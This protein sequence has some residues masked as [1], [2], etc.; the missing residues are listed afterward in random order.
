MIEKRT[1]II[2]V[3]HGQTAWNRDVRFRGQADLPLDDRGLEE[4][5]ATGCY[6]AQRWPA[7]AVYA[8][9]L[10]RALKTAEAIARAR[11]LTAQ[12]FEGLLDI[13]FGA[14]Q[15]HSPDEVAA[16]YPALLQA[17]WE[18][19]HTVQIPEGESLDDVKDRVVAGLHQ[20][21]ERHRGQTVALVGHSVVNRVLLCAVLGLGNEHFWRLRQDTCAVNVFEADE[22]GTF[23]IVLLNDTCHLQ[24]ICG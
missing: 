17:W 10:R 5:K 13:S 7:D 1:C 9:P 2:L 23:T 8:S 21:I 16:L 12:P 6:L 14:W 11:G 4:A 24:D 18:A 22:R 20:V 15:G 3:R 19:P